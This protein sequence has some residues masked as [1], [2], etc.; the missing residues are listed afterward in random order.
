MR[1]QLA[2]RADDRPGQPDRRVRERT[3]ASQRG[4]QLLAPDLGL[5]PRPEPPKLTGRRDRVERRDVGEHRD[6]EP[7][8]PGHRVLEHQR[9]V[10]DLAGGRE[11]LEPVLLGAG[12]HVPSPPAMSSRAE[13][14]AASPTRRV[15]SLN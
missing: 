3:A 5:D 13:T 2:L 7:E 4:L 1:Q 12:A 15:S 9:A 6:D 10:G 14:I 8:Q 11:Q